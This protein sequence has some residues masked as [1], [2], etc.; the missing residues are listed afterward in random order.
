[1]R[2][3]EPVTSGYARNPSDDTRIYYEAFGAQDAA[4][5]ILFSPAGVYA[6]SRLWKMQ[7]P[8]FAQ[9]GFRVVTYDCRGSGR[10]DRSRRPRWRPWRRAPRSS[11]T[12]RS[13]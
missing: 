3:L 12:P 2:A 5:T 1:M 8:Y 4:R 7:V 13:P 11:A 6:H 10:S 9:H